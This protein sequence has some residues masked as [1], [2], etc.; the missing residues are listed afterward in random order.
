MAY[1]ALAIAHMV[2]LAKTGI[3]S[4]AWDSTAELLALAINSPPTHHLQ[5]TCS[6]I[7]GMKTFRTRVRILATAERSSQQK[8]HLELVFREASEATVPEVK[9]LL[10]EEYGR[11]P[12][13]GCWGC[14]CCKDRQL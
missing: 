12:P 10:N 3:S 9:M 1:C 5:N 13:N 14:G 6:G 2:Y 4:D 11:L 7:F 8:D